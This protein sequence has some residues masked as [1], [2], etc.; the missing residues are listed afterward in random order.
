MYMAFKCQ[1][2]EEGGALG[3][4]TVWYPKTALPGSLCV[5]S[6]Q[7]L[8]AR[9]LFVWVWLI[10][11]PMLSAGERQSFRELTPHDEPSW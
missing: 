6:V 1:P 2:G 11:K 10:S 3:S 9:G 8:F 7:Q 4:A 5:L